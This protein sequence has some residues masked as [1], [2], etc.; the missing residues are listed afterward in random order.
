MCVVLCDVAL[1]RIT[2]NDTDHHILFADFSDVSLDHNKT[3]GTQDPLEEEEEEDDEDYE[4]VPQNLVFEA[5]K[6]KSPPLRQSL[7]ALKKRVASQP[8][9]DTSSATPEALIRALTDQHAKVMEA[10]LEDSRRANQ[11][12]RDQLREERQMYQEQQNKRSASDVPQSGGNKK[13]KVIS[14]PVLSDKS[15]WTIGEFQV[16]NVEIILK[17]KH[18]CMSLT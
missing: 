4:E 3:P 12:L 10:A 8:P 1:T 5:S 2:H 15:W 17:L 18:S 14:E 13:A 9:S 11:E 6:V 7:K 16:R